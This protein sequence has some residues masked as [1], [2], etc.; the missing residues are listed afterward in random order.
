MRSWISE[1]GKRLIGNW[2]TKDLINKFC[3]INGAKYFSSGI[4]WKYLVFIPA[5]KYIKYFSDT[6]QTDLSKSNGMP[7]DKENITKSDSNFATTFAGHCFVNFTF[8]K[9]NNK[10]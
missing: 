1:I 9:C 10:S 4:F 2:S 7:E 8:V 6:T 3:V 5:K